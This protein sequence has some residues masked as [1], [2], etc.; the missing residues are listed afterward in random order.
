MPIIC[1]TPVCQLHAK[2]VYV[3][4]KELQ[5]Y[6][7]MTKHTCTWPIARP[8]RRTQMYHNQINNGQ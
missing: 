8:K 1:I 5:A 3:V 4:L 6:K 2:T 7:Q